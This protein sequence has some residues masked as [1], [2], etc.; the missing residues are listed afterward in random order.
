MHSTGSDTLSPMQ[1]PPDSGQVSPCEYTISNHSSGC[2]LHPVP[3]G[4]LPH[5]VTAALCSESDG[6]VKP[7]PNLPQPSA[8]TVL[9][10]HHE[11]EQSSCDTGTVSNTSC[12]PSSAQLLPPSSRVSTSCACAN[13]NSDGIPP[14]VPAYSLP[15]DACSCSSSGYG[16]CGSRAQPFTPPDLPGAGALSSSDKPPP[17]SDDPVETLFFDVLS[18]SS[19][20]LFGVEISE[21]VLGRGSYGVVHAATYAHLRVAAKSCHAILQPSQRIMERFAD[22]CDM[23]S[24]VRHPSIVEFLGVHMDPDTHEPYIVMELMEGGTLYQLIDSLPSP[25]PLFLDKKL[26]IVT[27]VALALVYLHEVHNVVHRDLSSSNVLLTKDQKAK[28]S[29]FGV[30]RPFHQDM[31]NEP[32]TVAPGCQQYMPPEALDLLDGTFTQKSDIF[33]FGVLMVEVIGECHPRPSIHHRRVDGDIFQRVSEVERRK[34]DL[35]LCEE[36]LQ[37]AQSQFA[38]D[39]IDLV[40]QC[41][42]DSPD[43]RPDTNNVVSRLTR[44]QEECSFEPL[45][46]NVQHS[47]LTHSRA[48]APLP[49]KLCKRTPSPGRACHSIPASNQPKGSAAVVHGGIV[50]PSFSFSEASEMETVESE[51]STQATTEDPSNECFH[52]TNELLVP[53]TESQDQSDG[54]SELVTSY[55]STHSHSSDDLNECA[56][57]SPPT[58]TK[59]ASTTPVLTEEGESVQNTTDHVSS[60]KE[61]GV[62]E[63]TMNDISESETT[64]ENLCTGRDSLF[65]YSRVPL[66][67][68]SY[69]TEDSHRMAEVKHPCSDTKS[70]SFHKD[71][72]LCTASQE[73][74]AS[75]GA[76]LMKK[77]RIIR[78]H[79]SLPSGISLDISIFTTQAYLA[80]G[81]RAVHGS[82]SSAVFALIPSQINQEMCTYYTTCLLLILCLEYLHSPSS[83][84]SPPCNGSI[85]KQRNIHVFSYVPGNSSHVPEMFL[86]AKKAAYLL[87][88]DSEPLSLL[89]V[90]TFHLSS[91]SSLPTPRCNGNILRNKTLSSF[92]L[93]DSS[94]FDES[95][96][97][98]GKASYLLLSNFEVLS[99]VM[100]T[101]TIPSL[102]KG[103]AYEQSISLEGYHHHMTL[104]GNNSNMK[105]SFTL[106]PTP[107]ALSYRQTD[108]SAP[109]SLQQT[110]PLTFCRDDSVPQLECKSAITHC[111]HSVQSNVVPQESSTALPSLALDSAR[112]I[113]LCTPT[114]RKLKP[115]IPVLIPS[116]IAHAVFQSLHFVITR[117]L[118]HTQP[119]QI[120]VAVKYLS[121]LIWEGSQEEKNS[122]YPTYSYKAVVS[123]WQHMPVV[124]HKIERDGSTPSHTVFTLKQQSSLFNPFNDIQLSPPAKFVP[125]ADSTKTSPN[126]Q[127]LPSALSPSNSLGKSLCLQLKS[128]PSEFYS[129]PCNKILSFLL[130]SRPHEHAFVRGAIVVFCNSITTQSSEKVVQLCF[131]HTTCCSDFS[132]KYGSGT[133]MKNSFHTSITLL[134]IL[135]PASFLPKSLP[136]VSPKSPA[137]PVR[138]D[139]QS[140]LVFP[141]AKSYS[142]LETT[143]HL[144]V[145]KPGLLAS[146]E[147]I[148]TTPRPSIITTTL[149]EGGVRQS[150]IQPVITRLHTTPTDL[151]REEGYPQPMKPVF[152]GMKYETSTHVKTAALTNL[153]YCNHF[154]HNSCVLAENSP[155]PRNPPSIKRDPYNQE[156]PSNSGMLIPCDSQMNPQGRLTFAKHRNTMLEAIHVAAVFGCQLLVKCLLELFLI[157]FP[158]P[159]G[160]RPLTYGYKSVNKNQTPASREYGCS[161]DSLHCPQDVLPFTNSIHV[162]GEFWC[163]I[164]LLKRL[165]DALLSSNIICVRSTQVTWMMQHANRNYCHMNSQ[166]LKWLTSFSLHTPPH[167]TFNHSSWKISI[168]ESCNTHTFVCLIAPQ[169]SMGDKLTVSDAILPH[170]PNL[171]IARVGS[172][173]PVSEQF[174]CHGATLLPQEHKQNFDLKPATKQ[175]QVAHA[176]LSEMPH[177]TANIQTTCIKPLSTCAVEHHTNNN[178][179]HT[180]SLHMP[181]IPSGVVK[182]GRKS[183][184][185]TSPTA[186]CPAQE[187]VLMSTV[188]PSS[189]VVPTVRQETLPDA[190]K[191]IHRRGGKDH[192]H[193]KQR[194]IVLPFHK[195]PRPVH[196]SP[197]SPGDPFH[198]SP[199]LDLRT[200][201]RIV[202]SPHSHDQKGSQKNSNGQ[203][204]ES[205]GDDGSSPGGGGR[206][207]ENGSGPPSGSGSGGRDDDNGKKRNQDEKQE[208]SNHL[209][210]H[211]NPRSVHQSSLKSPLK[212][213]LE[214]ELRTT[215][216]I[217]TSPHSHDQ[218]DSQKEGNGQW[219]ENR[220][221]DGSSYGGGDRGGGNNSS[222]PSNS[223][224][225]GRDDD[226]DDFRRNKQRDGEKEDDDQQQEKKE[227]TEGEGDTPSACKEDDWQSKQH[228]SCQTR[229]VKQHTNSQPHGVH[230]VGRYMFQQSEHEGKV[231]R[232][233][234]CHG[235]DTQ[236]EDQEPQF[237]GHTKR[238]QYATEH[239][240]AS[241]HTRYSRHEGFIQRI[242]TQGLGNQGQ[243]IAHP[244]PPSSSEEKE[245]CPC[246]H[247]IHPGNVVNSEEPAP[248]QPLL[249]PVH[250]S[251]VRVPSK[252]KAAVAYPSQKSIGSH[253]LRLQDICTPDPQQS[254]ATSPPPSR[255]VSRSQDQTPVQEKQH[256]TEQSPVPDRKG[257]DEHFEVVGLQAV[258]AGVVSV[259]QDHSTGQCEDDPSLATA[260]SN[261]D[262][263]VDDLQAPLPKHTETLPIQ[264]RQD[265][266]SEVIRPLEENRSGGDNNPPS[267]SGGSDGGGS[268]NNPPSDSGGSDGGGGDNNPP[269]DS[270][271]R[272]RDDNNKKQNGKKRKGNQQQKKKEGTEDEDDTPS[273][274][275]ED[276]WESKQ[277][278]SCQPNTV[279]L[280]KEYSLQQ[281][282][283]K[284]EVSRR[285][286][287]DTQDED[288]QNIP[289][290]AYETKDVQKSRLEGCTQRVLNSTSP[291]CYN[292]KTTPHHTDL[293]ASSLS[294]GLF[295]LC[296]KHSV[297]NEIPE[298]E[299]IHTEDEGDIRQPRCKIDGGRSSQGPAVAHSSPPSSIEKEEISL[300]P[301]EHQHFASSNIHLANM[302]NGEEPPP[303]QPKDIKNTEVPLGHCPVNLGE[304]RAPSKEKTPVTFQCQKSIGVY[305]LSLQNSGISDHQQPQVTSPPPSSD[306][307][308]SHD[309]QTSALERK[310]I[311]EQ[312]PIPD[313]KGHDG[314]SEVV[315]LQEG[316]AGVVSASQD[317][318]TGQHQN[319][320]S[321]AT[322][323]S[324]CDKPVDDVPDR[325]GQDGQSGL[326][327]VNASVVSAS[328]N[329]STG[330]HQ[331]DPSLASTTSNGVKPVDDLP[332]RKSHDG[333]FVVVGVQEGDAGVVSGSQN[334]STGQCEDDPSPAATASNCDEPVD[335]LQA[336]LPRDTETPPIQ[337]KQDEHSEVIRPLEENQETT[338]GAVTTEPL[339]SSSQNYGIKQHE[340]Y[341]PVVSS[342]DES[343]NDP[344]PKKNKHTTEHSL[345]W[346]RS[347]EDEHSEGISPPPV[348]QARQHD[349]SKDGKPS[350]PYK[351]KSNATTTGNQALGDISSEA[352]TAE[353]YYHS[354][355]LAQ[356]QDNCNP[357]LLPN[358]DQPVDDLQTCVPKEMRHITE[359]SPI[360]EERSQEPPTEDHVA[361]ETTTVVVAS[362][363]L[364]PPSICH[365]LR[366]HLDDLNPGIPY[367]PASSEES[368]DDPVP[369]EKRH[370]TEFSP[371][372]EE[373]SQ[374]A[375]SEVIMPPSKTQLHG[376]QCNS[377]IDKE[378]SPHLRLKKSQEKS[379]EAVTER[380]ALE[381]TISDVAAAESPSQSDGM[382]QDDQISSVSHDSSNV[383]RHITKESPI[384]E[385]S[386]GACSEAVTADQ[387]RLQKVT[388]SQDKGQINTDVVMNNNVMPTTCPL[389]LPTT[390]QDMQDGLQSPP[391]VFYSGCEPE[392]N[393]NEVDDAESITSDFQQQL[394]GSLAPVQSEDIVHNTNTGAT[395]DMMPQVTA[396]SAVFACQLVPHIPHDNVCEPVTTIPI[397]EA[398][399]MVST[400]IS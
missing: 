41:L 55:N 215:P 276:A 309:H 110:T 176:N 356:H 375:C 212:S 45:N 84:S 118:L 286:G 65:A 185:L 5:G 220:G 211:E 34:H 106:S 200:T 93:V 32:S 307:S 229:G 156:R 60:Y 385:E 57:T 163:S 371:L 271:S 98:S 275:N 379:Q 346:K 171:L 115:K 208:G 251:E 280:V 331:V 210:F 24:R 237:L 2:S 228:T 182:S 317:H 44:L 73:R 333:H 303:A 166:K 233:A 125:F 169:I 259:S 48:R 162:C 342:R 260:A 254:Q 121:A 232:R 310:H 104:I 1:S 383:K 283:H 374:D 207:G 141:R 133:V 227:A 268:D 165:W 284:D 100:S 40:Y 291:P 75:S 112:S 82:V 155:E 292:D 345:M 297:V 318:S 369:K 145:N 80:I 33:S 252:E 97:L 132:P 4:C 202:T 329:H 311:T 120:E 365:G 107:L 347:S 77:G 161:I 11:G 225:G 289:G 191:T 7:Q 195:S 116:L 214:L 334:H 258:N 38:Q 238:D 315:G 99:F 174:M 88:S 281:P 361:G 197:L 222:P 285:L 262:K 37:D 113:V 87:L 367:M 196:K 321:L 338:H 124:Y 21:E 158:P 378:V 178:P 102:R 363:P 223:G 31:H 266:H 234:D 358:S 290:K 198:K 264:D 261:C 288:E 69:S 70:P 140:Q 204:Q 320:P 314:Q 159:H 66:C 366:E 274:C 364:Q 273:A 248:A 119:L 352:V 239:Q 235:T 244:V 168:G 394:H 330:Q 134:I 243:A 25:Q 64:N 313:K 199:P 9:E 399:V 74:E 192:L 236:D 209:P 304:V 8:A 147:N 79:T 117:L 22:E 30:A 71:L 357:V 217:V 296:S 242:L 377:N 150:P 370:V 173:H 19:Y 387:L 390:A 157:E 395:A 224:S 149:G 83:F 14:P 219:Q 323:T 43:D 122:F 300:N 12:S 68:D 164:E 10:G 206:G 111:I 319:D 373:Y 91:C 18:S 26:E 335:D 272:E 253:S 343:A 50:Q 250:F 170:N 29:D 35:R 351:T 36:K 231:D 393:E 376:S 109:L 128:V 389:P 388:Q 103:F 362:E 172:A 131:V 341:S 354:H 287:T 54:K 13:Y 355:G 308:L 348:T 213:P 326:Q 332:D 336:P 337:E 265:E 277:P 230:L 180:S 400:C 193:G 221:N 78:L 53:T 184:T 278:T 151:G 139:K 218:K 143:Y 160:S 146:H 137:C 186:K 56:N 302:V 245:L 126:Q 359:Q 181:S 246:E 295:S 167:S 339:Q 27:D 96:V 255:D 349:P 23:L 298:S 386:K 312:P 294:N 62:Q 81:V 316:N 183:I 293:K 187:C 324:T 46:T 397:E 306:A 398:P 328:Q 194:P 257:Q 350:P 94:Y 15:S 263:P 123:D 267:N 39:M 130:Y 152:F 142:L 382:G 95:L 322:T 153:L 76:S 42:D 240:Q 17:Y 67:A 49:R 368:A 51:D 114:N 256:I 58:I 340:D 241:V 353:P 90:S 16:S 372:L 136:S 249:V 189:D 175:G 89:K 148:H 282:E 59:V 203:G 135:V 154:L 63:N 47:H 177:F 299:Q 108:H 269:S 28:I 270:G 61:A 190:V 188:S 381:D 6:K 127:M 105:V 144:P 3:P 86:F 327:E 344:V 301:C 179:F 216:K 85:L 226:N 325:K 384:L 201:P 380:Q 360:L 391:K 92:G 392:T 305:S 138:L 205:S 279:Y 247:S 52:S 20:L 396:T 72:Q 101:F 129:F